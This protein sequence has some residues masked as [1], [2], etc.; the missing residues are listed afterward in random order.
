[1]FRSR[2]SK[3]FLHFFPMP[4][5][6]AAPSFG[7]DISDES[8]KFV[9]LLDTR[10]GMKMGKHGERVIPPGIIESGKIKDPKGM[11]EILVKLRKEVGIKSVR[12]S[13]PEEQ[14]YLF[15]LKL[16]KVG[17]KHIRESIELVLEEHV[18]ITAE[19]AI[20]DYE[21]LSEDVEHL[22]LEVATI[23]KG[24]I[25]NYLMIFKNSNIEVQSCELEAQAISRAVLQRGDM[26]CAS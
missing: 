16:D 8:I 9:E 22:E 5:F 4:R 13:L 10:I 24:V 14:I 1:M 26:A 3:F 6:F 23:P 2:L 15:K 25:E 11:E 17:M 20:F 19:D 18:P 12:V 7:L 21:I